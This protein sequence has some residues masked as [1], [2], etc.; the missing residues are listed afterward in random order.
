MSAELRPGIYS[1]YEV[2]SAD[3]SYTANRSVALI[4][5]SI[6][7]SNTAEITN[8]IMAA[9]LYGPHSGMAKL[10]A[11]L[12]LNGA[13]KIICFPVQSGRYAA[14][15]SAA[16]RNEDAYLIVC[17][18]QAPELHDAIVAALKGADEKSKFKLF[19]CEEDDACA[20]TA[21]RGTELNYERCV[22]VGNCENGGV[23]G[24]VAAALAGVIAGQADPSL[25]FNGAVLKNISALKYDFEESEIETLLAAGVTCV[26]DIGGEKSIVRAVTSRSLTADEPD[27]TWRELSTLLIVDTVLPAVKSSLKKKFSRC[28]NT[29]QTRGAIRS[30]AVVVLEDMLRRELI[31]SY[32]DVRAE[33]DEN[34]GSICR[35]SFEFAPA[36]GLNQIM[37]HVS[38]RV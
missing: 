6:Y 14:A 22:L 21:D 8:S 28:K 27:A 36:H 25:P 16:V 1:D 23:S 26:E 31:E 9:K 32:G 5:E 4:A 38:V 33:A 19:V 24:N 7:S 34:D 29:P 2:I 30:Q 12:F 10:A 20:D 15:I 18:S 17:D 11:T 13:G 37:L 3:L 35:L